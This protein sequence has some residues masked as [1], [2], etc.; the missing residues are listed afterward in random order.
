MG[1]THS[2]EPSL[3]KEYSEV[4]AKLNIKRARITASWKG[5]FFQNCSEAEN[6]L[7]TYRVDWMTQYSQNKII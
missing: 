2:K 6:K 7:E 4:F 1:L 3:P 5:A